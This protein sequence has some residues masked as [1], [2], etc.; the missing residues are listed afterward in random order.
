MITTINIKC[1]EIDSTMIKNLYYYGNSQNGYVG[2]VYNSNYC[3][4]YKNVELR[5]FMTIID[6]KSI[7]KAFNALIKD[8]H[9]YSFAG[10]YNGHSPLEK[11]NIV[12]A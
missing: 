10:N 9:D 11:M 8:S 6:S 1:E 3:Y 5:N 4:I 12:K 2:V 7:G